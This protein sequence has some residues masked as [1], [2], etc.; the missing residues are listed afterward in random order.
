MGWLSSMLASLSG[1]APPVPA[2]EHPV[3]GLIR[4]SYRPK[5]GRWLWTSLRPIRQARGA[6][7]VSWLAGPAGPSEAQV[8]FWSWLVES[9]EDLAEQAWS[10]LAEDV[11][12]WAGRVSPAHSWDALTWTGAAL[13]ADGAHA[14][15]WSLSFEPRRR[16]DV[17]LT[18]V[19]RE[20]LPAFVTAAP[21][22]SGLLPP[23]P[24]A[25]AYAARAHRSPV[26]SARRRTT[27]L[28]TSSGCSAGRWDLVA[29]AVQDPA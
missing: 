12:D 24:V 19:F 10:L 23:R 2:V 1:Q 4:A 17:A 15:E 29:Q 20:G 6:V 11:E 28:R 9:I 27:A 16:P 14:S 5:G 26:R 18:V 25:S 8:A 3:L 21:I 7:R 22:P 13:P